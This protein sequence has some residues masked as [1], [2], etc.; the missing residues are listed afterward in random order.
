MRLLAI[1]LALLAFHA[2]VEPLPKPV[3]AELNG[4][5]WH[6][7]CPVTLSDLRLLTVTHWGFDGRA[8]NGQ[9]VVNARVAAPLTKVFRRLYDL[10]F[11]IR[12]LSVADAYGPNTPGRRRHLR[13][14][15]CRQAV[16]SPCT[17]GT[18]TGTWSMHAY[19]EAIDL[20]PVENPYVGC[21]MTRDPSS[22]RYLNRSRHSREWSRP[23]S[24]AP[25]LRSAGA[26]AAPGPARRRTTC[27]SPRPVISL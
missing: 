26:G 15:E 20:N 27:T 21:G 5:Y 3:R 10:R 11:P 25:S 16:P 1:P 22:K 13:S 2:N 9:L 8:H 18:G 17:G 23:P 6:S 7:G 24:S 4:K 19:G 14:F 12:H